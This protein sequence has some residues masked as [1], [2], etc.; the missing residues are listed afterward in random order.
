MAVM[1]GIHVR[2]GNEDNIWRVKGE[3]FGTVRQ[4]EQMVR[5]SEAF[6]R[7][8]ATAQEAREMMQI[9][10]WY[11]SIDETLFK[12]GLPPNRPAGKQ[13]FVT[14][15]TTGRHGV[16]AEASDSHPMAYCLVAPTSVDVDAPVGVDTMGAGTAEEAV[17]IGTKDRKHLGGDTVAVSSKPRK[18]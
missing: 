9:G 6:G 14:W 4:V 7:K 12:L 15:E 13:G 5:L 1:L 2:V 16:G 18:A 3:R 8:V 10:T 17:V 11:D